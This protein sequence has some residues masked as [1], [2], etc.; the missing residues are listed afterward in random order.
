[1]HDVILGWSKLEI[2]HSFVPMCNRMWQGICKLGFSVEGVSIAKS[3]EPVSSGGDGYGLIL[4]QLLTHF[5]R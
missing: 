4:L 3:N 2:C 1:M 5:L